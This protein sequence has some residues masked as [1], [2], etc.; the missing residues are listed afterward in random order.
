MH[1]PN[2]DHFKVA[3]IPSS[4]VRRQREALPVESS[5]QPHQSVSKSHDPSPTM[6]NSKREKQ[7]N[8]LNNPS[9][10]CCEIYKLKESLKRKANYGWSYEMLEA[11]G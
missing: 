6:N 1:L 10:Y 7:M 9:E 5:R 4:I 2:H 11:A 3:A 8:N